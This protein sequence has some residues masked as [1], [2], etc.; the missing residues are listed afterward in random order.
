M[1]IKAEESRDGRVVPG[2]LR[3]GGAWGRP[4]GLP[5]FPSI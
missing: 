1:S 2:G 4:P 3:T 5:T